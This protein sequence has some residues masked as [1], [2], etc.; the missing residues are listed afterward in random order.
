[1]LFMKLL[2][3]LIT[4]NIFNKN[5]HNINTIGS[6]NDKNQYLGYDER[7]INYHTNTTTDILKIKNISKTPDILKIARYMDI[8]EKIDKLQGLNKD[9]SYNHNEEI[10]II[11]HDEIGYTDIRAYN[12]K[13]GLLSD[14]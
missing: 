7:Y 13:A 3:S 11:L 2:L 9:E 14:W 8:L 5:I 4:P 10:T 6:E 12:I 1:M